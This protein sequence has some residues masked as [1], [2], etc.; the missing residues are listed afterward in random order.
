MT[1]SP[2]HCQAPNSTIFPLAA[3]PDKGNLAGLDPSANGLAQ[4]FQQA[5]ELGL[6]MLH[7]RHAVPQLLDV[8]SQPGL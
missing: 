7:P 2:S 5:F 1:D 6:A 3:R 8:V 4:S